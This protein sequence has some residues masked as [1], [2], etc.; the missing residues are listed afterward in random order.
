MKSVLILVSAV[1]VIMTGF[2]SS[3]RATGPG[4]GYLVHVSLACES[5]AE[6][7]AESYISY[8]NCKS[9]CA[10]LRRNLHEACLT[11]HRRC[12]WMYINAHFSTLPSCGHWAN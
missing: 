1:F 6:D 7:Y 3:A 2:L 8:M 9:F 11:A 5:A 12:G 10:S 4:P